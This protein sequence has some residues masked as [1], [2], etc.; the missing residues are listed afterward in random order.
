MNSEHIIIT[1]P[2]CQEYILVYLKEFNCKIFRHG[3]FKKNLK[4]IDPH[5]KKTECDRLIKE[6][7]LYGC[8]KPFQ[9][10]NTNNKIIAVKCDYI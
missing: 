6:N 5:L 4:Q 8:G 2:H 7:L 9:L 3:T 10:I 1:C